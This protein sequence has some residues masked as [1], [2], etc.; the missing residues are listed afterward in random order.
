MIVCADLAEADVAVIVSLL[1]GVNALIR[2]DHEIVIEGNGG[3]LLVG[4]T[5]EDIVINKFL[6]HIRRKLL[7]LFFSIAWKTD[8]LT[9]RNFIL[10]I[11]R[12]EIVKHILSKLQINVDR[13][14]VRIA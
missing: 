1:N 9:V 8:V 7:L 3:T 2:I 12:L 11:I 10:S 14:L 13:N 4:I 6:A 5:L